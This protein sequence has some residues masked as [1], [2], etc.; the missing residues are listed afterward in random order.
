MQGRSGT[1][2]ILA[3][4]YVRPITASVKASFDKTFNDATQ[5]FT[6]DT[7]VLDGTD[8][9]APVDDNPIQSWDR[10]EYT[11]FYDRIIS[12]ETTRQETEPY[13]VAQ[14]FSDVTLN[15][16]DKYFTP[17]SGSP[18]D[19]FIIPR[20]PFRVGFGFGME[21]LQQI[22]GLTQGMPEIDKSSRTASFHIVDFM[23]YLYDKDI[24][25]SVILQN[26]K[27]HEVLD[28]LF[29]YLGLLPA[30][31]SLDESLNTIKFFYVEKGT[32]F[33]QIISDLLEAEIGRLFLDELGVI[34]FRN[35]YNYDTVPVYTFDSRNTIDYQVADEDLIINSVKITSNVRAVQDLQSV[36]RSTQR[37][38]IPAG[39]SIDVF[40]EFADPIT[41]LNDPVYSAIELNDS[42]FISTTD[43]AGTTPYTDIEFAS[44]DLFSKA[45][46]LTFEN[47]GAS[48]AYIFHMDL[49]GTPAK[50][51]NTIKVEEK[52]QDSID[53]FEEQLYT[54]DNDFIQDR[55]GAASRALILI[56]D[57][58][59]YGSVLDLEVKGNPALQLGDPVTIDLDGYQGLYFITKEVNI[60][61]DGKYT[62]R[63]RVRNK[64][65]PSF[66]I[67]DQSLLDNGDL[68]SP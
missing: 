61:S 17:N 54:I 50:V 36:W 16:Y 29:Q 67:L 55:D 38:I 21:P 40:V 65:I 8:I 3:K 31:Y 56:N 11:D 13:S 28:Y 5:F 52:N 1:F 46:K 42:Y 19:Q 23:S 14:S 10:Y 63:L 33:G 18:I 26:V 68:L 27:T 34:R 32:K 64:F 22:V 35:R 66:F 20:R 57:Y 62:Q 43:E 2:D 53:Q 41:T 7:S 39:E 12:L 51:V 24:G 47:T 6:L 45:A 59:E 4:G 30:Q 60:I 9:L 15:N 48:M 49:F 44:L 25:E 37:Y 58:K